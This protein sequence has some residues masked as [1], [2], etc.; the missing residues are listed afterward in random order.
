[1]LERLGEAHPEVRFSSLP[2]MREGGTI[3]ELGVRGPAAAVEAAFAALE[4][5]LTEAGIAPAQER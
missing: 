3:V 2:E 4:R 5:A 1:M